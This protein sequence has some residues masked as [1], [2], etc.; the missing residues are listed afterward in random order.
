MDKLIKTGYWVS[1][2]G[3][4]AVALYLGY[5]FATVRYEVHVIGGLLAL[6]IFSS[7]YALTARTL[8]KQKQSASKT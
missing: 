4:L 7:V 1:T 8:N 6:V 5:G 2:L 3:L